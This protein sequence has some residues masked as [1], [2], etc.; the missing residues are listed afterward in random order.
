MMNAADSTAPSATIQIVNEVDPRGQPAPAEQPQPEERRLEEERGQALHGQRRAE[1][2]ADEPR[3]G[4]PVHAELELLDQ[5]R[6]DADGDVDDQQGAEEAGEAEVIVVP[7]PVP[8]RVQDG[9]EQASPIVTGT[10]KKW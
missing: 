2:V 10:K 4:G 9:R 6:H 1:D 5:S 3:I 7:A 8:G